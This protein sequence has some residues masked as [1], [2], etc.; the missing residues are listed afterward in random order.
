M[1]P[2]GFLVGLGASELW[3]SFWFYPALGFIWFGLFGNHHSVVFSVTVRT[4]F[5]LH[6]K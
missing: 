5:V 1:S 6:C 4:E 2:S 3:G